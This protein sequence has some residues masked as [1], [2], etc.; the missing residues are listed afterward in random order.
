M[1]ERT[2]NAKLYIMD[3][4]KLY[5]YEVELM[6]IT[7]ELVLL[8]KTV[9]KEYKEYLEEERRWTEQQKK[10]ENDEKKIGEEKEK[11]MKRIKK[12][13]VTLKELESDLVNL[14]LF[15]SSC[16]LSLYKGRILKKRFC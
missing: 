12:S 5:N 15:P 14:F 9:N 6:P 16:I 1:T 2:F 4:F 10:K 8:A 3:A 13:L 7:L 11:R